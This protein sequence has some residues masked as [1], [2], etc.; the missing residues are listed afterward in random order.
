MWG[1]SKGQ[2]LQVGMTGLQT[3][4][5]LHQA[6]G[7]DLA[8]VLDVASERSLIASLLCARD[9]PLERGGGG[10]SVLPDACVRIKQERGRSLKILP[11][12]ICLNSL[13]TSVHVCPQ[14][15]RYLYTIARYSYKCKP[16]N[17]EREVLRLARVNEDTGMP[18]RLRSKLDK[19][20]LPHK[21]KSPTLDGLIESIYEVYSCCERQDER[22][23]DLEKKRNGNGTKH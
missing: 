4:R 8:L 10:Q 20:L 5:L 13:C 19:L 23:R 7:F 22:I 11:R 14:N 2:S 9:E 21:G 6:Q 18:K 15:E 17:T 1:K 16:L 3:G 12:R